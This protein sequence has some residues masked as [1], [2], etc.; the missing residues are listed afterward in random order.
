MFHL[1]SHAHH[2]EATL[3]RLA[4]L[5]GCV[6]EYLLFELLHYF[7]GLLHYCMIVVRELV[8][9]GLRALSCWVLQQ[10][11]LLA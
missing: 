4:A 10:I 6:Q 9:V 7:V 8:Q 3:Q 1:V 11:L 5:G 2:A